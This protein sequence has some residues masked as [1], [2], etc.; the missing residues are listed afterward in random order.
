M[1]RRRTQSLA[2]VP[3]Q[4]RLDVFLY[5]MVERGMEQ[6]ERE[7]G[8]VE[9]RSRILPMVEQLICRYMPAYSVLP[10][11]FQE[12][13]SFVELNARKGPGTAGGASG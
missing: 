9:F 10:K 8:L 12:L 11:E 13:W 7:H 5:R 3:P 4:G 6:I 1:N 2:N